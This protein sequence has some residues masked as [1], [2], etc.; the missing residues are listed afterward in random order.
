M[1]CIQKADST[2][3]CSHNTLKPQVCRSNIWFYKNKSPK[4]CYNFN[5]L[6]KS[7]S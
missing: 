5:T 4:K 3:H 2:I 7:V 1:G 6:V